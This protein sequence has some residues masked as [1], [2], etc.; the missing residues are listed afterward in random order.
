MRL[1]K[2]LLCWYSGHVFY[3]DGMRR[4]K[5]LGQPNCI[6]IDCVRCGKTLTADYGLAL[7]GK[8]VAKE[9]GV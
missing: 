4:V 8:F 9:G 5:P 2:C 3:N 1:L 6:A 7:P